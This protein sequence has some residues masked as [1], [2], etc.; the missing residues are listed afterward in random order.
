MG[1]ERRGWYFY[2]WANS[3]F[4]TTVISVFF[5]PYLNS[6]ARASADAAGFVHPL[7]FD[8]RAKTIFPLAITI[9]VIVQV[10]VLPVVGALAD[11][12]GRKR[13]LLGIFAGTGST[14]AMS[15]VTVAEARYLLG[16]ALLIIANV[17]FGASAVVYN[18]FLPAIAAPH[19]RD[20]VSTRGWGIG[21]LGAGI[22]LALNLALY[23]SHEACGLSENAAVRI[24]LF[25]A[26]FWWAAFTLIPLR[27]LR[28][29][30][31]ARPDERAVRVVRAGFTR[32]GRTLLSLR[33]HPAAVRFLL[34][35]LMYND[36]V[37]TVI[38]MSATY[39]QEELLIGESVVISALLM[40]QF[41]AFGGVLVFGE[42]ARRY[43]AR[44]SVLGSLVVWVAAIMA[45]L[46]MARG[47]V[48][49]FLALSVIIGLTMGGTQALSRSLFTRLL[50]VGHEAG[51]FGFYEI[52]SK[53]TSWLGPLAFALTLQWTDS[54]R[55]AL[56]SLVIF[57]VV[58]F[59]LL[60]T[61]RP[62]GSGRDELPAERTKRPKWP[63][64]R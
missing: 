25:S 18:A 16:A 31:I 56:T 33:G 22:L 9:S 15:M 23:V 57:F 4:Y 5:G 42:L 17:A 44:A 43:G 54:Y 29:G 53:G 13:M 64:N 60:L 48:L 46:V 3:A 6:I 12:T 2:D 62:A 38:V 10:I 1:R 58:G 45:A 30:A 35:Y 59:L 52:S 7:G 40:V 49:Q 39:A 27:T 26:G 14:A 20:A 55:A 32:L 11:Q 24:N 19:E 36:G 34:A 37:Q 8:L 41:V 28:D 47:S 50:P 63:S 61:V 21:Y 51:Y